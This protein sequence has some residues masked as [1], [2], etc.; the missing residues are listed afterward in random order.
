MIHVKQSIH[1]IA[2]DSDHFVGRLT[3]SE[4]ARWYKRDSP[5]CD[6]SEISTFPG[7]AAFQQ[8]RIDRG[9]D[10][11]NQSDFILD[12]FF[13]LPHVLRLC[14]E[15]FAIDESSIS[16]IESFIRLSFLL[17]SVDGLK[18]SANNSV[19]C[20][21]TRYV[22]TLALNGSDFSNDDF[23]L[24][25]HDYV[26]FYNRDENIN[27]IESIVS[28]VSVLYGA[29]LV[30]DI[31]KRWTSGSLPGTPCDFVAVVKNWESDF[32][33]YPIQWIVNVVTGSG[34]E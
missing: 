17:P 28:M 20:E 26:M 32:E 1:E 22:Q 9:F 21:V 30:T 29:P 16:N 7:F 23:H 13:K 34:I 11:L 3:K 6:N 31:L 5:N 10:F 8:H 18:V 12:N 24:A 2:S 25:L 4:Y 15:T 19:T 33:Q 14:V 27:L